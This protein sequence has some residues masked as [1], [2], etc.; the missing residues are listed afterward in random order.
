[1]K[2]ETKMAK[3][4]VAVKNA[5]TQMT[6][7]NAVQDELAAFGFQ[8]GVTSKSL[9]IPKALT[10]QGLSKLVNEGSAMVGEIRDS[11]EGKLLGGL[12]KVEGKKDRES[13]P[14]EFIPIGMFETWVIFERLPTGKGSETK[15]EYVETIPMDRS[16]AHWKI[17]ETVGGVTV[18]RDKAINFYVLGVEDIK[19]GNAFP[20]VLSFR[21][22]SFKGG[23]N[24]VTFITKL[25][26]A[27]PAKLPYN[28][29]FSLVISSQSNDSGDFFVSNTEMG[30]DTSGDE[31]EVV[32]EWQEIM[33][34]ST[35]TIDEGDEKPAAQ[36]SGP[37]STPQAD[38]TTE[39]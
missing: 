24:M 29:V 28:K 27:K 31:L 11:L 6:H 36:A 9:T 3:K 16:N 33:K 32:K 17:E 7:S 20:Y 37:R 12:V 39:Y 22:T 30:R 21:R 2:Q 23:M 15:D 38:A 26:R 4:E 13:R 10:M 19:T 5:D 14:F 35:I 1:M 8:A 25:S 34:A 18:R